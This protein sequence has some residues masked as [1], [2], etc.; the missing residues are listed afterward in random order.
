MVWKDKGFTLSELSIV[1]AI[2]TKI[3]D[4]SPDSGKLFVINSVDEATGCVDSAATGKVPI[5]TLA[6]LVK[7]VG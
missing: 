5:L 4:R 7:I 6:K 3:D 2:E 1:H